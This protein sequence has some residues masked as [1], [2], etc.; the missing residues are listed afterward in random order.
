MDVMVEGVTQNGERRGLYGLREITNYDYASS[1]R[2]HDHSAEDERGGR[3][4][5]RRT[6]VPALVSTTVADS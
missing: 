5:I 1:G 2:L 4:E 6:H 3:G